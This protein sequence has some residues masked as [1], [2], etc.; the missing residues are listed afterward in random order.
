MP[1]ASAGR[2]LCGFLQLNPK[3]GNFSESPRPRPPPPPPPAPHLHTCHLRLPLIRSSTMSSTAKLRYIS[4]YYSPYINAGESHLRPHLV[5]KSEA[6][7]PEDAEFLQLMG[8][9]G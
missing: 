4:T 5:S 8:T 6:L 7:F 1:L 2:P 3:P 9:R